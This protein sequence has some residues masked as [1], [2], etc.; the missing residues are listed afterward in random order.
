MI[1]AQFVHS[2]TAGFFA[3]TEFLVG[4]GRIVH[5]FMVRRKP[6]QLFNFKGI[7][8]PSV[9]QLDLG[10]PVLLYQPTF[11]TAPYRLDCTCLGIEGV[12][13]ASIGQD[14]RTSISIDIPFPNI[15]GY[16]S[17]SKEEIEP[18]KSRRANPM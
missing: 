16:D 14:Q 2:S 8:L 15:E 1:R 7:N 9:V 12:C 4:T 17:E 10:A 13:E 3:P 11:F 6:F 18:R 5:Q